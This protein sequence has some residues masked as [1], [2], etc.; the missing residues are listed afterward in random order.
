[1]STDAKK[2]FLQQDVIDPMVRGAWMLGDLRP[3]KKVLSSSTSFQHC[4]D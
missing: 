2:A 4:L 3:D 1:M